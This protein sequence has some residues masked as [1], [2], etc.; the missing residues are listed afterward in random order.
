MVVQGGGLT[1]QQVQ[2]E[3]AAALQP[4]ST[5][6]AI[7]TLLNNYVLT[8]A[9]LAS[10][11]TETDTNTYI[12]NQLAN[13]IDTLTAGTGCLITGSGNSRTIA[14]DT[15]TFATLASIEQRAG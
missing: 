11:R 12:T 8:S 13:K 15:S 5:T 6:S 3:I 7:S 1:Q 10:Y 4:F 2:N 14:V 9:L